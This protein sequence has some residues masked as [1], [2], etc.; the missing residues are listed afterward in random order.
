MRPVLDICVGFSQTV[1]ARTGAMFGWYLGFTAFEVKLPSN[2]DHN[3]FIV[4]PQLLAQVVD[5]FFYGFNVNA[6]SQNCPSEL[7][8]GAGVA[9]R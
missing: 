9:Q 3:C 6:I 2:S 5:L 7:A 4:Q 8:I 1:A